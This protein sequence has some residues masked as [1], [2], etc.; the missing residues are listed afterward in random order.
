MFSNNSVGDWV[1]YVLRHLMMLLCLMVVI[2]GGGGKT[3]TYPQHTPGKVG[4]GRHGMA[5]AALP[6][7]MLPARPAAAAFKRQLARASSR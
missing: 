6:E 2:S 1:H 4:R 7:S 3:T 5:G